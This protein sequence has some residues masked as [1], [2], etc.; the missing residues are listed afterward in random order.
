MVNTIYYA[1]SSSVS[2]VICIID[3]KGILLGNAQIPI[4]E[5]DK[6][7]SVF[8]EFIAEF[9]ENELLTKIKELTLIKYDKLLNKAIKDLDGKGL[10]RESI[11]GYDP[12]NQV[13]N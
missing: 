8:K 1:K 13:K 2:Y 12:T 11:E 5:F 10:T 4:N 7:V 3:Y 6:Y 9:Y